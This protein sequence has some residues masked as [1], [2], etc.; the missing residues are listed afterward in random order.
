LNPV[1]IK[2]DRLRLKVGTAEQLL[3]VF[4]KWSA[5]LRNP[6]KSHSPKS[7]NES[8]TATRA[9]ERVYCCTGCV[10]NYNLKSVVIPMVKMGGE[11][12]LSIKISDD[13]KRDGAK[14]EDY[15]LRPAE[16]WAIV[17]PLCL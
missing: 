7:H 9:L 4:R 2:A 14:L 13:N 12:F 15:R 17:V 8:E 11:T 10:P 3:A 16:K 6:L 1:Q 5:K